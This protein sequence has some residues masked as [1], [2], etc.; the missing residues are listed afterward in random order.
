MCAK[1][2]S[3]VYELLHAHIRLRDLHTARLAHCTL[4]TCIMA[5][6]QNFT[7][8][9][10]SLSFLTVVLGMLIGT[11]LFLSVPS[12]AFG[13]NLNDASKE[14][15]T[16]LHSESFAARRYAKN[17]QGVETG[18]RMLRNMRLVL[19]PTAETESALNNFLRG[20]S[21][22]SSPNFHRWLTADEY[23]QRF[24][25]SVS[26][27]EKS[28]SWLKAIGMSEIK[29]SRGGRFL[30]FSGPVSSVSAGFQTEIHA[31][32]VN[33]IRHFANTVEPTIS[34]GV[35]DAVSSI[36]GL[37]DFGPTPG[38]K[39]INPGYT[40]GIGSGN[41]LGPDDLATI[42]NIKPLYSQN[43]D[44][45]GITIAVPGMM[46]VELSDYQAFR[47][48]FGLAPNDY[49]VITVDYSGPPTTDSGSFAWEAT[50]NLQVVG[51]VARN[52]TILYVLSDD[53]LESVQYVIDNSLAQIITFSYAECEQDG[54]GSL[55]PYYQGLAQQA[56]AEGI[57]WLAASGDTG[58]AGCDP[59]GALTAT[60]GLSV[61]LPA[62][63]PEVTGVGGIAFVSDSSSE[64]W[65][66][67]NNSELGTALSYV[68][69]TAWGNGVVGGIGIDGGGGGVSAYIERPYFQVGFGDTSQTA[70][71]VPD[72]SLDAVTGYAVIVDGSMVPT[73]GTSAATPAFAGI[74]ALT[75]QYLLSQGSISSPGLGNVNP[76]LYALNS[77]V[78][79]AFHDI[80]TGNNDVPCTIG[81]PDCTSGIM[82]WPA[83]PGYDMATGLGSVDA[84]VL[85]SNWASYAPA[86][87]T[88]TT[89]A[90]ASPS[91]LTL[92]GAT[93]L[94]AAVSSTT[95]GT[96]S[97]TVT[98][99][100]GSTTLG[101][102][103][104]SGGVA[105]LS[106]VAA[107]AANGFTVGSD[108]ITAGYSGNANFAASTGSTN[109]TVAN[110]AVS[111]TTISASPNSVTLG[112]ATTLTAAVSSTT[113]GT[114]SGTV[115]FKVGSTTLG[116]T[117]VSGGTATLSNVAASAANGFS[118]G[119]D[120]I[121]ASYSG[122]ANYPASTGSTSLTVASPA[123][124]TTTVLA[125]PSSVTLSGATT[126]TASVSSSTA[127]AITGTVTFTIGVTTL[128]TASVSN[129]TATLTSIAAS[130][131][132]GFSVGS[133]TIT[134]AYSGNAIFAASA[135]SGTLAVTADPTTITVA[136]TP[137]SVTLGATATLSA[138]LNSSTVGTIAGTVTFKVGNTTIGTAPVFSG[139]A[140]LST[141]GVTTADGFSVGS[142]S[143]TASYGG[144][145]T[146]AA[147]TGSG[148]LA[149]AAAS[150]VPTGI[151]VSATPSSVTLGGATVL[152]ASVSSSTAGSIT[153]TVTFTMGGTTLGT[154]SVSGGT[155]TLTNVA[156]T[157]A[158]G[159]TI[160]SDTISAFYS[161]NATFA[162]SSGNGSLTVAAAPAP[163]V[164]SYTLVASSTTLTAS[165][166]VTLTLTSTNYVGTVTLT[167]TVTSTDA[168]ASNVTA[169]LDPT[170]V[171]LTSNGTGT[172]TLAVS[173]NS[174]ASKRA[175]AVPWKCCVVMFGAVLLGVPLTRGKKRALTVLLIA[176]TVSAA[177]FM[178]ACGG[179]SSSSSSPSPAASRIYTVTVTPNGSGTVTDAAPVSITLT[180]Q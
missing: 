163:I 27:I 141:V 161:G 61:V 26:A 13:Q 21:V 1:A 180:V 73:G 83:G 167:P 25:A 71:M 129:G 49:T 101:T 75:E 50:V 41:I 143:V 47:T 65:A 64:Y 117:P 17:D 34:A 154:A 79:S 145:S 74:V 179:G 77:N 11:V 148:T 109:L 155:A 10:K 36:V 160:G 168:T 12:L 162:S 171:T 24:G 106:N 138:V 39:K 69:E 151:T 14:L 157:S 120:S 103:P 57:T 165:S 52:S 130:A 132:N 144:N 82:G 76:N 78:P 158:N 118:V 2:A 113:S 45:T 29:L 116:T 111:T 90:S 137:S 89:T 104:V 51:M 60:S 174:S 15:A 177:G 149:V 22:P 139:T 86:G 122:N 85:A 172:S 127:G 58:A 56:N 28:T 40:T 99:K 166:S 70:R 170:S 173:A 121:T 124:T 6:T 142:D 63:I 23:A 92:G 31:Y 44:G 115:T 9:K 81:T 42:Y 87:A 20:Q 135:G 5:T 96:I 128:G 93:T 19:K 91:S 102:A 125:S 88:T 7:T 84:Y 152:T 105:T 134:A 140:T 112:G 100:V 178:I 114:I 32:N 18:D 30:S 95:S 98:F 68:P 97:G 169:S 156:A 80:T 133:D 8:E 131:A 3:L 164:T 94:T 4:R 66:A 147:S 107:T 126:L 62:S 55:V 53:V 153:G 119:S 150:A 38:V 176:L 48:K 72:V 108:S 46:S 33:G 159:F 175:P 43:I 54:N 123:V 110:L 37:N 35:A 59:M 136:A 146:F 67:N 16:S